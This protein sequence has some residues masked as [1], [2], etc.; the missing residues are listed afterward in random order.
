MM[1][2]CLLDLSGLWTEELE[3]GEECLGIFNV[4]RITNKCNQD[5]ERIH[6]CPLQNQNHKKSVKIENGKAVPAWSLVGFIEALIKQG[7]KY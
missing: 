5:P 3:D 2:M 1:L 7:D 6:N 4:H